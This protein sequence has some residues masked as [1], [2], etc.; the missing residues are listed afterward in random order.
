MTPNAAYNKALKEGPSNITRKAVLFHYTYLYAKNVDKVI[1][2]IY[3]DHDTYI[4]TLKHCYLWKKYIKR[5]NIPIKF[6]LINL[7][8]IN[9]L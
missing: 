5:H 2:R 7:L 4:T 3:D 8:N 1:Y 6:N 9:I